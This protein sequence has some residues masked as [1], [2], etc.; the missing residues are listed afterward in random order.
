MHWILKLNENTSTYRHDILDKVLLPVL[1]P[2]S[3]HQ[4]V[5][6]LDD[7]PARDLLRAQ[8]LHKCPVEWAGA[9]R[10]SA[11]DGLSLHSLTLD[12]GPGG[13]GAGRGGLRVGGA[14]DIFGM[15]DLRSERLTERR[16]EWRHP[17]HQRPRGQWWV[18]D[19]GGRPRPVPDS[20][21]HHRD[22]GREDRVR[23]TVIRTV[24]CPRPSSL[25]FDLPVDVDEAARVVILG[26]GPGTRGHSPTHHGHWRGPGSQPRG[27]IRGWL[28]GLL[29]V[30]RDLGEAPDL[31]ILR[32]LE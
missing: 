27:H 13:G 11:S 5:V 2:G 16:L 20:A 18:Q 24:Q 10:V 7:P 9:R 15:T 1:L 29:L 21:L 19:R 8:S 3:R 32:S 22:P 14:G 6:H 28:L 25:P 12:G 31:Q 26:V 4:V 23:F 17:R 30:A